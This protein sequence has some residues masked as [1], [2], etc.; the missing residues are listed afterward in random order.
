MFREIL[1]M[2]RIGARSRV[3]IV[4]RPDGIRKNA[5]GLGKLLELYLLLRAKK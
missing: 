2:R 1:T 3:I 5:Q 4:T